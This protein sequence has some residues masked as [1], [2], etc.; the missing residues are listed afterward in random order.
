MKFRKRLWTAARIELWVVARTG[1]PWKVEQE[2]F[3][4]EG[5]QELENN[6]KDKEEQ[7]CSN[8]S[9]QAYRSELKGAMQEMKEMVER[10]FNQSAMPQNVPILETPV[11]RSVPS[12]RF[13]TSTPFGQ[14]PG[15]ETTMGAGE[16]SIL[17]SAIPSP[18]AERTSSSPEIKLPDKEN[19]VVLDT[20][21]LNIE[22]KGTEVEKFITRKISESIE[23][24][25]G[26]KTRD[27]ELLKKE[28]IRKWGRATPLRRLTSK[29][30]PL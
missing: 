6:Q 10:M 20:K 25:E 11:Q 21:K 9:Q 15:L 12:L 17:D 24:M 26:H 5:G 8:S 29:L 22:F 3:K 28:M 19:H 27:W 4:E 7:I 16:D 14:T 30:Y 13:Q 18:D 2:G 23:N 1:R